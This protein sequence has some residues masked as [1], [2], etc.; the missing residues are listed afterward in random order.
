[1]AARWKSRIARVCL[2]E[3]AGMLHS[4]RS[5]DMADD[6]LRA[7][8]RDFIGS[9]RPAAMA[10]LVAKENGIVSFVSMASFQI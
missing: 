8:L 1:M 7:D 5:S 2:F 6:H 10:L 3:R 9:Y 4:A